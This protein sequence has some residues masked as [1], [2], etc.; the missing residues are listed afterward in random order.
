[1][2]KEKAETEKAKIAVMEQL[3]RDKAERLGKNYVPKKAIE[4][5]PEE[6]VTLAMS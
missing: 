3:E 6:R 1:M 2:K 5:T 4:K